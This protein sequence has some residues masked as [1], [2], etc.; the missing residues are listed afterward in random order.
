MN[1]AKANTLVV[2]GPRT[3]ESLDQEYPPTE[4]GHEARRNITRR[5]PR[6]LGLFWRKKSGIFGM[7]GKPPPAISS[8]L[9]AKCVCVPVISETEALTNRECLMSV[10]GTASWTNRTIWFGVG[11]N[12]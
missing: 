12:S 6:E 4:A 2:A 5:Y 3:P 8:I 9:S 10:C 11:R 1:P 7:P